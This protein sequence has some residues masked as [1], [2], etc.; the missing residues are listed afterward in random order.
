MGFFQFPASRNLP[1]DP[2]E[3]TLTLI[4]TLCREYRSHFEEYFVDE[5]AKVHGHTV[6]RLPP[7]HCIL[8]PI[9]M[10][11]V[12]H[13]TIGSIAINGAHGERSTDFVQRAVP[14]DTRG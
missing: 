6:L 13:K 11:M 10:L 9:E 1:S 5:L 14:A 4:F 7:Y 2:D 12:L 3:M 8:N